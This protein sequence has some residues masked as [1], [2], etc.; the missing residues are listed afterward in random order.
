M[1]INS[2]KDLLKFISVIILI[3]IFF[4]SFV[5]LKDLIGRKKPYIS[6]CEKFE[7]DLK[8]TCYIDYAASTKDV[9]IC[10]A[11]EEQT[12]VDECYSRVGIATE[13]TALCEKIQDKLSKKDE[14]SFYDKC[15]MSIAIFTLNENLCE[16]ILNIDKRSVCYVQISEFKKNPSICDKILNLKTYYQ[17]ICYRIAVEEGYAGEE[18]CKKIIGEN[19]RNYCYIK[20]YKKTKDVLLCEKL[21]YASDKDIENSYKNMC[22]KDIAVEKKDK[23]ICDKIV[24][25]SYNPRITREDCIKYIDFLNKIEKII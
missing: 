11:F 9:S 5:Y 17:D 23:R 8:R 7:E 2:F 14:I 25:S 20:L 16:K 24:Y 1:I 15:Y 21:T 22:Y 4:V 3:F 18:T 6:E 19:E 10:N 12:F 13:N